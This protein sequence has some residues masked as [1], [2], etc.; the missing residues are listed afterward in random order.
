VFPL[1]GGGTLPMSFEQVVRSGGAMFSIALSLALPFLAVM[2]LT[3]IVL[4]VLAR[5]APQLNIFAVG[6]PL[7]VLVGLSTLL[8][9]LPYIETPLRNALIR[10]LIW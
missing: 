2:L 10:S 1:A 6:F 4:G 8:L 5:V 3:N 7:T 9:L